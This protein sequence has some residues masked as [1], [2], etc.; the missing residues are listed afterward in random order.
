MLSQKKIV[1]PENL[2]NLA[3]KTP[4]IPAGVVCA[5]NQSVMESCKQA[6]EIGLII[7]IFIGKTNIIEEEA[8]KLEWDINKFTIID[9]NSDNDAATAGL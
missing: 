1:V 3:I 2:I 6:Y 9:K 7:P 8:K 4:S 5:H